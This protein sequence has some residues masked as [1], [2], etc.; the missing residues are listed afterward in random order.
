MRLHSGVYPF[1]WIEALCL[2]AFV[3]PGAA[4]VSPSHLSSS[5][6]ERSPDEHPRLTPA[7]A[8]AQRLATQLLGEQRGFQAAIKT[9][10]EV[11]P[12]EGMYLGKRSVIVLFVT[13]GIE[14]RLLGGR[15]TFASPINI[16]AAVVVDAQRPAFIPAS[17]ALIAV[18]MLGK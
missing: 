13:Q 15:Q 6:V 11:V 2:L 4:Q 14:G 7:Q 1:L 18:E 17:Q 10:L 12:E 5:V 16:S 8:E 9:P 3:T